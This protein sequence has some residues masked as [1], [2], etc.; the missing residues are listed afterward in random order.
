MWTLTQWSRWGKENEEHEKR[1][2]ISY[3]I[4][5]TNMSTWVRSNTMSIRTETFLVR[6][7][8]VNT[9]NDP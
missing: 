7:L 8:E 4:S 2:N 9:G 3:N 1:K 5:L 6:V